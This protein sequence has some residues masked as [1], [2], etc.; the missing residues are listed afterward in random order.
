[1]LMLMLIV[2][3]FSSAWAADRVWLVARNGAAD[4]LLVLAAARCLSALIGEQSSAAPAGDAADAAAVV[5]ELMAASEDEDRCRAREALLAVAH[6]VE[7][8]LSYAA[9]SSGVRL[10]DDVH[11]RAGSLPAVVDVILQG[12]AGGADAVSI[13]DGAVTA[14]CDSVD[15]V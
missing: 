3:A 14:A 7:D 1:E 5:A 6:S 11:L 2:E 4:V 9:G 10:G 12:M 8:E 15:C 13:A